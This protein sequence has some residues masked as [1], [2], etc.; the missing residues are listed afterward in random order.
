[1]PCRRWPYHSARANGKQP[2]AISLVDPAIFQE[3]PPGRAP[4]LVLIEAA[5]ALKQGGEGG[6]AAP[7]KKSACALI[8]ETPT[9]DEPSVF[10][11]S[12]PFG[13]PPFA[14]SIMD[15]LHYQGWR[16]KG[17][18]HQAIGN[19]VPGRGSLAP[20]LEPLLP[21]MDPGEALAVALY[22]WLKYVG[23]G[24]EPEAVQSAF[25]EKF[26][27][28]PRSAPPSPSITGSPSD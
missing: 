8:R 7:Y 23:S 5:F 4:N 15:L 25:A 6:T 24:L 16:S 2:G 13:M 27:N 22:D 11:V 17:V 20:P 14:H 26:T 9:A 1:M 19:E 10:A 28:G 18:W 12:F 21:E 3:A